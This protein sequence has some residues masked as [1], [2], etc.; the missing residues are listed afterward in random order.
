MRLFELY[1]GLG[2]DTKEFDQNVD[3]S[4]QKGQTMQGKLEG[5]FKGIKTAITVAGIAVAVK[6]IGDSFTSAASAADDV[7][8]MS[9]KLGLSREAYQKWG[10]VLSQNGTSIDTFGVGMK[11]LQNAM[12]Q[13]TAETD[14]ALATLGLSAAKLKTLTPEKALEATIKAF[15]KLPEG[16]E[17]SATAV[18]LFGRQG[19]ELLPMLN[20]TAEATEALKQEAED[21]GLVLSDDAVDAGVEFTDAMDTLKRTV[22]ATGTT[23]ITSLMP[24]I[25]KILNILAPLL[26]NVLPKLGEAFGKIIEKVGPLVETLVNGFAAAITW[27]ADNADTLIPILEGVAGAIMVW[28]GAQ[29]ILNIT[30]AANPIMAVVKAAALLVAGIMILK[31]AFNGGNSAASKFNDA[32]DESLASITDFN[33]SWKKLSPTLLNV[34]DLLSSSGKSVGELKAA[35]ETAETAITDILSTA[36]EEHRELRQDEL[37][38]I[39]QYNKDINDLNVELIQTY[40][41]QQI[42]ELKK[43]MLEENEMTQDQAAQRIANATAAFEASNN[44]AEEA[45]TA[46]LTTIENFHRTQGTLDSDGYLYDQRQAKTYYDEQLTQNDDYYQQSLTKLAEAAYQWVAEDASKWQTLSAQKSAYAQ[47]TEAADDS[48]GVAAALFFARQQGMLKDYGDNY[49]LA[50]D[51][52]NVDNTNAFLQL[53]ATAKQGNAD[54]STEM[55]SLVAAILDSFVDLPDDMKS[56]GKDMLLGLLGGIED[57]KLRNDLE[58]AAQGSADD[59]VD[60]IWS[61]WDLGSPSRVAKGMGKNF[62]EG[63]KGGLQGEKQSLLSVAG[64]IAND[65]INS[66]LS[67]FGITRYTSSSGKVSYSIPKHATGLERVPYDGYI[68]ELH[69]GERVQTKAEAE[70]DRRGG[71]GKS[72]VVNMPVTIN[73]NDLSY[74]DTQRA[75]QKANNRLREALYG[76]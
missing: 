66:F 76:Y 71:A 56:E 12:V 68:A 2:L 26:A 54:V 11:T 41:D 10:Y 36:M 58:D 4:T 24:A 57:D 40:R 65:L 7:D 39:R 53:Y 47:E 20:Q 44:L 28:N 13:G 49:A 34:E 50:M 27:I 21:L 15:Q 59:V 73:G 72:V 17:K 60:T 32:V 52:I 18:D 45:Y 70:A 55:T 46:Q 63:L 62:V 9:Q 42:A 43:I 8:K 22:S 69:E 1:A 64:S 67:L 30:M 29:A 3:T 35:I 14:K 61:A 33:D 25:T 6:K 75:M 51:S 31:D 48:I 37:D 74:A 5:V 38:D 19:M 23:F 16:A